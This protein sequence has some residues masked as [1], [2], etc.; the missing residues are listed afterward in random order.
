MTNMPLQYCRARRG[1][2]V[3]LGAASLADLR[4]RLLV[5][6]LLEGPGD[7]I[8]HALPAALQAPQDVQ[9]GVVAQ[10]ELGQQRKRL[11]SHNLPV[12]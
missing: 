2:D 10:P 5:L 9:E 7:D 11:P 8:L 3:R 4:Q 6:K 1:P 12:A